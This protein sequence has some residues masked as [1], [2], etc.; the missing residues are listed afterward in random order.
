MPLSSPPRQQ[1]TPSCFLAWGNKSCKGSSEKKCQLKGFPLSPISRS[2]ENT[3]TGYR[4]HPWGSSHPT[5][6]PA[7]CWQC[8]THRGLNT[9]GIWHLPHSSRRGQ[10]HCHPTSGLSQLSPW[11][12]VGSCPPQGVGSRSAWDQDAPGPKSKGKGRRPLNF[13][14]YTHS[15]MYLSSRYIEYHTITRNS[16][17]TP[18]IFPPV[19][20]ERR[21]QKI[22]S[23]CCRQARGQDPAWPWAT[24]AGRE[25][26][27]EGCGN[28][29]GRLQGKG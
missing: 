27:K 8:P 6:L 2:S 5:S 13:K 19:C 29:K 24:P 15:C 12:D 28:S 21:E 4:P 23:G 14:K 16:A 10:G 26:G 22:L 11:Q 18:S 17:S 25:A 9:F 3:R 20:Q 7:V 1:G